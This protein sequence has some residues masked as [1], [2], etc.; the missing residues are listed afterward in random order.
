MHHIRAGL[1]DLADDWRCL[2]AFAALVRPDDFQLVGEF[3]NSVE[4]LS[5][6]DQLY[7]ADDC[8]WDESANGLEALITFA[9]DRADDPRWRLMVAR[10]ALLNERPR[11]SCALVRCLG[12]R[13]NAAWLGRY[14]ADDLGG[15]IG[16]EPVAHLAFEAAQHPRAVADELLEMSRV[17]DLAPQ[18]A[19]SLHSALDAFAE[20][21]PDTPSALMWR[22]DRLAAAG[23]DRDALS[24]YLKVLRSHAIDDAQRTTAIYRATMSARLSG[25]ALPVV[26]EP[27]GYQA[28]AWHFDAGRNADG[29]AELA[30]RWQQAWPDDFDAWYYLALA[31]LAR[32]NVDQARARARI[33]DNA[34]HRLSSYVDELRQDAQAR[35]P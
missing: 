34:E 29:L 27:M 33:P 24:A 16:V 19:E 1:A 9:A 12:R 14:S 22:A 32:D 13:A 17:D 8:Y 31:E 26:D 5:A 18:P 7:L 10:L 21:H 11:S 30:T 3:L 15:L 20:R 25:E 2:R 4:K 35:W 6:E 28:A 23:D